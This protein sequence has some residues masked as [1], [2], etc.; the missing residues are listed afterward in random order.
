M[1]LVPAVLLTMYY[2]LK[3]RKEGTDLAG[4]VDALAAR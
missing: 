2:D 1:P 3:L 4:R